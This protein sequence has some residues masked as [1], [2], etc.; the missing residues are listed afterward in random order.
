MASTYTKDM[1][2]IQ[3]PKSMQFCDGEQREM[4]VLRARFKSIGDT[5]QKFKFSL[6]RIQIHLRVAFRHSDQRLPERLQQHL[7]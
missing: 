2:G 5:L 6:A 3:R 1:G 7:A 4:N